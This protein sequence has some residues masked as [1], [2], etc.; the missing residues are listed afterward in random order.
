MM[1][2]WMMRS[3]D[4]KSDDCVWNKWCRKVTIIIILLCRQ[5]TGCHHN[6]LVTD[7]TW[8]IWWTVSERVEFVSG[9][10]NHRVRLQ[11]LA[12]TLSQNSQNSHH[13]FWPL[14]FQ[15]TA[16]N[17]QCITDTHHHW[18]D[19]ACQTNES[20]RLNCLGGVRQPAICLQ[21]PMQ[22]VPEFLLYHTIC[23]SFCSITVWLW[24][25]L[26]MWL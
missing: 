16:W 9:C 11:R 22:S 7:L 25:S 18:G 10:V 12:W 5:N 26:L 19:V 6:I 2:V 3:A 15:G 20:L 4:P 24:Y 17:L 1:R 13:S 14:H 21:V 8:N 23:Y